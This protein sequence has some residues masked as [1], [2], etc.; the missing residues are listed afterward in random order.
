VAV[1]HLIHAIG[2]GVSQVLKSSI[3]ISEMP[4]ALPWTRTKWERPNWTQPARK[5][6]TSSPA[7]ILADACT[8][9]KE[10]NG[11]K[12]SKSPRKTER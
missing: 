12:K 7:K 6:R 4:V 3:S 5:P 9:H 1:Q 10:V 8:S 2:N 11:R